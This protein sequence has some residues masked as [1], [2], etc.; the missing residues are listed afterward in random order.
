MVVWFVKVVAALGFFAWFSFLSLWTE[1]A[2]TRPTS[3]QPDRQY[4]L[5]THGH[6]VYLTH[7]EVAFFHTL[8]EAAAGL[9]IVALVVGLIAKRQSRSSSSAALPG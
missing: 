2:Y 5:D 1:Y 3:M 7:N 8:G 9:M 4:A 6:V